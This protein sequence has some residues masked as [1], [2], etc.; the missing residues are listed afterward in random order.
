MARVKSKYPS[1]LAIVTEFAGRVKGEDP[2][3]QNFS[4]QFQE[5]DPEARSVA[6]AA[7]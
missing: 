5:K 3:F 7:L 2:R 1:D 4:E 6:V